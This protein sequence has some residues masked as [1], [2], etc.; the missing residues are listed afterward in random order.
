MAAASDVGLTRSAGDGTSGAGEAADGGPA[1]AAAAVLGTFDT[2][3]NLLQ[4][5]RA[6]CHIPASF[7]PLDMLRSRAAPYY[8]AAEGIKVGA[9]EYFCDGGI[10]AAVPQLPPLA[11]STTLVQ[12]VPIAGPRGGSGGDDV[13]VERISPGD[14]P[15]FPS[16]SI[17]GLPVYLSL[18][19]ARALA[20][21]VG[22]GSPEALTEQ[23]KLGEMDA[24]T[25]W[26]HWEFSQ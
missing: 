9:E 20:L 10:S 16:A 6:S 1:A 8:P 14:F 24:S 4:A 23:F 13:G 25:W 3:E 12:V 18:G 5:V 21:S 7:H 15:F 2:R 17:A 22:G 19:N 11:P 26:E